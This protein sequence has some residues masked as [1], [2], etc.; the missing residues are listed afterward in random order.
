[1]TDLLKDTQESLAAAIAR[2][3]IQRV[4]LQK[5]E[6][7]NVQLRNVLRRHEINLG[8][9]DIADSRPGTPEQTGASA[10]AEA[11]AEIPATEDWGDYCQAE[12]DTAD[13][14]FQEVFLHTAQAKVRCVSVHA[15]ATRVV[16]MKLNRSRSKPHSNG[17]CTKT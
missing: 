10:V 2:L 1:M 13:S 5:L 9:A 7:E 15:S 12:Q 4:R 8:E 11:E 14:D 17:Q 6:L 16:R 3:E